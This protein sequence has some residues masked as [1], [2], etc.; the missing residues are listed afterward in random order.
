MPRAGK[1][2][3]FAFLVMFLGM[4]VAGRGYYVWSGLAI[5]PPTHN[6]ATSIKPENLGHNGIPALFVQQAIIASSRKGLAKGSN[7]PAPKFGSKFGRR[8]LAFAHLPIAN[9]HQQDN[10]PTTAMSIAST[11]PPSSEIAI[12]PAHDRAFMAVRIQHD[13]SAKASKSDQAQKPVAPF[14]RL[15]I[16]AYA[17]GRKR[18]DLFNQRGEAIAGQYGGSQ[19]G[20]IAQVPLARRGPWINL[21]MAGAPNASRESEVGIGIGWQPKSSLPVSGIIERRMRPYGA[22]RWAVLAVLSPNEIKIGKNVAISA[23]S[24]SGATIGK[25]GVPFFDA[26]IGLH[27]KF[28][29]AE[30]LDVRLGVG[31]W[32]GGQDKSY[33]IDVGPAV[34]IDL[35]LKQANLHLGVDWRFRTSGSAEPGSGPT[36]T[37]SSS[38]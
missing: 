31:S 19:F 3:P 22:D 27:K 25:G 35:R 29:P 7:S 26:Q 32:A 15:R 18:P 6:V 34:A 17:F 13:A 30:N 16:Y 23:Y 14:P 4:W 24:Q 1:G 20:L 36:I 11:L 21:R 10:A 37:V 12:R 38:F 28:K 9:N 5:R 33:R 8:A 2:R